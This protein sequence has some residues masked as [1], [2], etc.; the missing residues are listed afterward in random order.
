MDAQVKAIADAARN[1]PSRMARALKACAAVSL[2]VLGPIACDGGGDSGNSKFLIGGTVSGLA[3]SGLVL[4]NNGGDARSIASDGS[5]DFSTGLTSGSTYAI[6]IQTQPS[7]P[8][9]SCTV[10][11][12][13][14]VVASADVVNV[15]VQCQTLNNFAYSL[16]EGLYGWRINAAS[17]ELTPITL[18]NI[19]RSEIVNTS[20]IV[21]TPDGKYMYLVNETE[22]NPGATAYSINA[23]TGALTAVPNGTVAIDAADFFALSPGGQFAYAL[24][25]GNTTILGFSIDSTTGQL[26]PIPGSPFSDGLMPDGAAFSPNGQYLYVPDLSAPFCD[27]VGSLSIYAINPNTGALT[28][29]VGSPFASTVGPTAF[30]PDGKFAYAIGSLNGTYPPNAV[31]AYSVSSSGA[32]TPVAGSPFALNNLPNS[33]TLDPSATH[34]YAAFNMDGGIGGYSIDPASGSLAPIAGSP[35]PITDPGGEDG[36]GGNSVLVIAGSFAYIDGVAG[37]YGYSIA[38]SGALIPLSVYPPFLDGGF[39]PFYAPTGIAL[40]TTNHLLF[41]PSF[42]YNNIAVFSIDASTGDIQLVPDSPYGPVSGASTP[43]LVK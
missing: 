20:A 27:C 26:I 15:S 1:A 43:L 36:L 7:G 33:L 29:I 10:S 16:S 2:L 17:G 8:N 40:D 23:Q 32:L 4:L 28:P 30:T 13:S 22:Q 11:A 38:S 25:G 41:I 3:G 5:F 14:G 6:T 18:G 24:G 12:A 34:L 19:S 21:A 31:I 9:Q 37:I 39:D 42:T 35:F